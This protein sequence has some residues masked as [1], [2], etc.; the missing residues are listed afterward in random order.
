MQNKKFASLLKQ[1]RENAG[2]TQ[3][4]VADALKISRTSYAFYEAA[5]RMPSVETILNISKFYQINPMEL[6]CSFIPKNKWE[7][8]PQY[9]N[10]RCY[11]S[12]TLTPQDQQLLYN[13][14]QLNKQQKELV[15]TLI[16]S[17][18]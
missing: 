3:Y 6:L 13:Y 4:E 2:L 14:N 8:D 11:G 5:G 10:F 12:D 7:T 15:N 18:F 1:K 9:K 16:K 17:F